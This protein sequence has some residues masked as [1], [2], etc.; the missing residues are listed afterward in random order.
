MGAAVVSD[1]VAVFAIRPEHGSRLSVQVEVYETADS[2]RR[3]V[4]AEARRERKPTRTR[5]LQGMCLG[6]TVLRRGRRTPR[7]AILRIPKA[8]L[9]MSTITH[10]AF[11]A[12]CRWAE[13]RGHGAIP[14]DGSD[15]PTNMDGRARVI[16]PL[17]LEE[18][19]ATVHDA[20]CRRIV[21][22][23]RRRKLLP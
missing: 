2:M 17:S 3:V 12:T 14:V 18:R 22:E 21:I 13:R 6:V 5:G 19:A 23:C 20:L 11:H 16:A 10:E 4:R 8:H 15:G 9:T 1:P 7:F